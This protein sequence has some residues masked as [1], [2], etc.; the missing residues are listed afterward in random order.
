[1]NER[2]LYV[3]TATTGTEE[4]A[5]VDLWRVAT[6]EPSV[7]SPVV[8]IA[9]GAD[10][11]LL[12]SERRRAIVAYPAIAPTNFAVIDASS[13]ATVRKVQIPYEPK[14]LLPEGVYL[15]DIPMKGEFIGLPLGR[16]WREPRLPY[17]RLT[18]VP[19]DQAGGAPAE[20]A[21]EAL[22]FIRLGGAVGG[23]LPQKVLQVGGD[24]LSILLADP[25]GWSLGLPRP[26]FVR[27]NS[28]NQVMRLVAR[29]EAIT[30]V[31]GIPGELYI[32]PAGKQDWQHVLLPFR[33]NRVRIFGPWIAAIGEYPGWIQSSGPSG[34]VV[35]GKDDQSRIAALRKG[36]PGE[37]KRRSERIGQR[38]T[39][40]DLYNGMSAIFP[41][42]LVVINTVSGRQMRISTGQGDSEI[43]LVTED[44]VFYRVNDEIY[45]AAILEGALGNPIK[46]AVGGGLYQAHWAFLGN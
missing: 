17:R 21:M 20:M 31:S 33:S 43:L 26:P 18:T 12:D 29:I 25:K 22:R 13:P 45:A 16:L 30:V 40:D 14:E 7:P 19:L 3:L 35:V 36:S 27:P 28:T 6:S 23:A 46:L 24:P 4:K 8:R 42:E 9:D 2:F 15:L 34:T 5:P 41:G 44:T 39:V 10:C 38:T 1:V 32:L 11:V 37:E